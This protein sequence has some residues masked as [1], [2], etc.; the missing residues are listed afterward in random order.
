[1]VSKTPP[2]LLMRLEDGA[3]RAPTPQPHQSWS[4]SKQPWGSRLGGQEGELG[5]WGFGVSTGT[6]PLNEAIRGSE[7]NYRSDFTKPLLLQRKAILVETLHRLNS[8][9][10]SHGQ[11]QSSGLN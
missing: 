9:S 8:Y 7:G 5:E 2:F 10:V 1:M 6:R 3:F 4:E 11:M